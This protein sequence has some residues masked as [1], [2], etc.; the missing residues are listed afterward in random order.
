MGRMP[1]PADDTLNRAPWLLQLRMARHKCYHC[2]LW[3]EE[4]QA[5][6]CWTTTEAAVTQDLSEDLRD[7]WERVRETAVAV[8][9]VGP[10]F[11]EFWNAYPKRNGQ[12]VGKQ[13][14]ARLWKRMSVDD[15]AAACEMLG[16]YAKAA[17]DYPKDAERYLRHRLWED[18][19]A[20]PRRS[21]IEAKVNRFIDMQRGDT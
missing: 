7:A 13:N 19:D 20:T 14:A 15:R 10:S 21:G 16:V 3:V 8:V 2:K 4:G 9:E 6:D 11:D 12:R 18:L 5:H 1:R 17:G